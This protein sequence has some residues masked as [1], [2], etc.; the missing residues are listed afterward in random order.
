MPD[1]RLFHKRLGHS[2]KVN[3]LTDAEEIVWRTYILAA[4]DF[5]VMRFSAVSLQDA[6]DRLATRKAGAVQRMLE[7]V[8]AV[9]L[10][11]TFEH[12]RR[13]YCYQPDWQDYQKVRY[14]LRTVHPRIPD[15][16]LENCT[17]AT[18]WLL[19]AW[20]GGK[21]KLPTWQPPDTGQP[22]GNS[23][24][25][26]SGK[27]F[28]SFS[29]KSSGRSRAGARAGGVSHVPLIP[30]LSPDPDLGCTTSSVEIKREEV[31]VPLG[32]RSAASP[33]SS[34]AGQSRSLSPHAT[35]P[36]PDGNYA[37]ILKIAHETLEKLGISDPTGEAIE[38]VKELCARRHIDYG[39][40]VS[41]DVVRRA[42]E[43]AAAQR[44]LLPAGKRGNMDSVGSMA[45]QLQGRIEAMRARSRS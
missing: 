40:S 32:E 12:Q 19:T 8:K 5:G 17:P 31:L 27:N 18:R 9:G 11:Q 30:D 39:A 35:E 43:S 29:G 37:V 25:N 20:P 44:T 13:V 21:L 14:P 10:V 1:D 24:G 36:S 41:P 34:Q 4:D 33:Q 6:H 42:V 2:N 28:G 45:R 22:S 7:R 23:S 3:L 26:S 16:V 38:C 15:E